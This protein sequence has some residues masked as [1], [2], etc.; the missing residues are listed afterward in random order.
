MLPISRPTDAL[1]RNERAS[2]AAEFGIL[3]LPFFAVIGAIC[4]T[5]MVFFA[6][7]VLDSAVQ[8]ATRQIRTGQA[9]TSGYTSA[10]FKDLICG[11][12]YNLFNCDNLKVKVSVI[13]TFGSASTTVSTPIKPSPCNPATD[14]DQCWNVTET[15]NAGTGSSI[16]L[17]EAYYKWPLVINFGGFNLADQ[18]DGSRLLA[19][20]RVFRNEPFS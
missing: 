15:Y 14:P 1:A 9:Q 12:L 6:G 8:D 13:T 20:V 10:T 11:R 7:Q 4:E 3:A 5:S 2:V 16:V 18:P 19:A 17:V